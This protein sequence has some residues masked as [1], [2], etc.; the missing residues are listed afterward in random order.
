MAILVGALEFEGPHADIDLL[1]DIA[2]IYAILCDNNGE[3]ELID[4]GESE[5]VR[6]AVQQHPDRDKWGD[7]GL[8]IAFAI[9]YT[10]DLSTQERREIKEALDREFADCV[11]A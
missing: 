5:Y 10:S 4:M 7:E 3:I 11:A 2:G 9:H 6:Q 1:S 8:D